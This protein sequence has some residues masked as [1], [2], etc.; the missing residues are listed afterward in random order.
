[1]WFRSMLWPLQYLVWLRCVFSKQNCTSR[2]TP[3]CRLNSRSICFKLDL[4]QIR[5]EGGVDTYLQVVSWQTAALQNERAEIGLMRQRLDASVFLIKA[6]G[7]G[8]NSSRLTAV[9]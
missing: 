4:L 5:Y 9:K 7:R 6:L 3:R 8:W 2:K 1:V